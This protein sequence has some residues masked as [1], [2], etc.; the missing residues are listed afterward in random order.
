[1]AAPLTAGTLEDIAKLTEAAFGHAAELA[2]RV[3]RVADHLGGGVPRA[4]R[5]PQNAESNPGGVLPMVAARLQHLQEALSGLSIELSRVEHCVSL[6]DMASAQTIVAG[7]VALGG[8]GGA[9]PGGGGY[10]GGQNY[11]PGSRGTVG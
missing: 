6:S 8:G 10:Y 4:V 11:A 1:M 2:I 5:S 9:G 7:G 3:G